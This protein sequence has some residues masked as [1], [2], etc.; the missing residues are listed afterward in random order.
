VWRALHGILP[1][2]CILANRHIGTSGECPICQQGP[3][4]INHLLFQCQTARDLWSSLD[5]HAIIEQEMQNEKSGSVVLE[6]L[7]RAD[8]KVLH[9]F[10]K[11]S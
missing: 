2:K 11:M 8:P 3:E 6:N 5:L 4:D 10:T 7:L 9:G 1:Q